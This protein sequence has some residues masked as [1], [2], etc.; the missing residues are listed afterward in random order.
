MKSKDMP[1]NVNSPTPIPLHTHGLARS[2]EIGTWLPVTCGIL[3]HIRF[4]GVDYFRSM[5]LLALGLICI[6]SAS[7]SPV[8]Q[9]CD[10]GRNGPPLS[11]QRVEARSCSD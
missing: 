7:L 1:F 8:V 2:G 9:P 11:G 6:R 5:F 4:L 10:P 3:F